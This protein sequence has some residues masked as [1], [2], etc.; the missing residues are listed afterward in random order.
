[1]KIVYVSDN[2]NKITGRVFEEVEADTNW[3]NI[4]Y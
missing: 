2:Y 1:M 4:L 3:E